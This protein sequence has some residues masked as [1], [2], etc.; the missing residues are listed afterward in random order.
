METIPTEID[1]TEEAALR[2]GKKAKL[3]D[4]TGK[5]K[6][7]QVHQGEMKKVETENVEAGN[8][9]TKD[10]EAPFVEIAN[11]RSRRPIAAMRR[12]S[13]GDAI[14]RREATREHLQILE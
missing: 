12:R 10:A 8:V 3:E 2:A 9:T 7:V 6:A 5:V 4:K 14:L 1:T 11:S 13:L